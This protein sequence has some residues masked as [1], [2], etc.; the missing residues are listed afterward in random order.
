MKRMRKRVLL[1][2]SALFLVVVLIWILGNDSDRFGWS[3]FAFTTFDRIPRPVSDLQ[4]RADGEVRTVEKTHS[5]DYESVAWLL[6]PEP[7]V[8]IIALGWDR[9][10]RPSDRV[11]AIRSCALHLLPSGEAAE[12]YNELKDRG[13]RVA[14]H[15]HS[16]C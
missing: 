2:A 9:V 6:E 13:V 8:L 5:L 3:G 1:A 11:K 12:L 15:Y 14:I 10:V 16:T 7:E 4:I